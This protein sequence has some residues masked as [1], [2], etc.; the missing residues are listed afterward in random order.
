MCDSDQNVSFTE[1]LQKL[2]G[3]AKVKKPGIQKKQNEH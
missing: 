2:S 1:L 3:T